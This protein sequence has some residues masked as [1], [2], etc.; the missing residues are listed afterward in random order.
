[1]KLVGQAGEHV[2]FRVEVLRPSGGQL[3]DFEGAVDLGDTGTAEIQFGIAGLPIPDFGL[4][5]FNIFIGSDLAKTV[6][7]LVLQP[8]QAPAQ[9]EPPPQ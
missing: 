6:G 4:Y 1:M 8:P 9:Q 5:N 3:I 7:F 2:A